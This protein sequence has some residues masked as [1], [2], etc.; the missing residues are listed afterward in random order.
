MQWLVI[1]IFKHPMVVNMLVSSTPPPSSEVEISFKIVIPKQN[2][3]KFVQVRGPC[4]RVGPKKEIK[5]LHWNM[6]KIYLNSIFRN[7]RFK[8]NHILMQ[9]LPSCVNSMCH[10]FFTKVCVC[11]GGGGHCFFFSLDVCLSTFLTLFITSEW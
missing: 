4:G 6:Q 7:S 1:L 10:V 8:L 9:M 11:V 2:S 5:A 3:V